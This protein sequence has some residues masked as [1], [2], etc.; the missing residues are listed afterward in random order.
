M[1][2][3]GGLLATDGLGRLLGGAAAMVN[4]EAFF[5]EGAATVFAGDK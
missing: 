3:L 5:F 1:D 4:F 2:N